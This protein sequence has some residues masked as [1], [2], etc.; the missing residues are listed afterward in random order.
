MQCADLVVV[1][2]CS[3]QTGALGSV[4]ASC[5]NFKLVTHLE[6][7]TS[8]AATC[9]ATQVALLTATEAASITSPFNLTLLQAGQIGGAV[10][11]LWALAFG[12]RQIIRL[13][14]ESDVPGYQ[15]D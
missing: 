2:V 1:K 4:M 14:R 6:L 10:M 9:S 7:S 12:F 8:N 11:L 15:T 13:I 3:S 5:G